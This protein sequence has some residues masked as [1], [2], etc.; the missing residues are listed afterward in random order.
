MSSLKIIFQFLALASKQVICPLASSRRCQGTS[1]IHTASPP[2]IPVKVVTLYQDTHMTI[3]V[4][5]VLS[6]NLY[7]IVTLVLMRNLGFP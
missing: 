1:A 3:L 2:L 4:F 5:D 6:F 7:K